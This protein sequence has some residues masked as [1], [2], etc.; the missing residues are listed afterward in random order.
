MYHHA[1]SVLLRGVATSCARLSRSVCVFHQF[2]MRLKSTSPNGLVRCRTPSNI[3]S[4]HTSSRIPA[5][6][7]SISFWSLAS[8]T[9][10]TKEAPTN[11]LRY[12][13]KYAKSSLMAETRPVYESLCLLFSKRDYQASWRFI[14]SQINLT[15]SKWVRPPLQKV[16]IGSDIN[17]LDLFVAF[18][19]DN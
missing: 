6:D 12:Q 5:L 7:F 19:T 15:Q 14:H 11:P 8:A 18:Q 17:Y 1:S 4:N 3:L 10:A 9:V 16:R 2:L 13:E